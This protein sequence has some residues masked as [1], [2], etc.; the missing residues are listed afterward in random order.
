MHSSFYTT[1]IIQVADQISVFCKEMEE[2]N[3]TT[4]GIIMGLAD[5]NGHVGREVKGFESVHGGNRNNNR[6][7]EERRLL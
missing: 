2:L 6:N 5:F 4:N 3:K 7:A 1:Q